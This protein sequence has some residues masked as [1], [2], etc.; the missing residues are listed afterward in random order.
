MAWK[1]LVWGL[2]KPL[3]QPHDHEPY[4]DRKKIEQTLLGL[5]LDLIPSYLLQT[6]IVNHESDPDGSGLQV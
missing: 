6:T 3:L 4:Q 5:I 2:T 1:L